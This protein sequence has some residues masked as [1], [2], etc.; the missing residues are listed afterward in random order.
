MSDKKTQQ[1]KLVLLGET[2]VGKTSI[3][4]RFV[5]NEFNERTAPTIGGAA[6]RHF[7]RRC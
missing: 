1:N 7:C 3:V 2:G 4:L 6:P 5:R